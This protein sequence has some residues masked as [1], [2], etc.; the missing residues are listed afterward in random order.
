MERTVNGTIY[1]AFGL[2]IHSVIPFQEL[3]VHSSLE[4][5]I[6]IHIDIDP[7][8]ERR[9]DSLE[10]NRL[11]VVKA[12]FIMFQVPNVATFLIE[13]GNTILV[14]PIEGSNMD[15]VRLFLLGTCMG[16]ILIQ[17]RILPLHGS[18]V[19]I[20]GKAYAIVGESGAGK[21]TLASALL[22]KGYK[23]L[24]D[25]IIPVS[26]DE[27]KE[28]I[29]TPAYPQQ[30]LWQESLDGFGLSS[31]SYKPIY[32]RKT[33]FAIPVLSQFSGSSVPLVGIFE[34]VKTETDE[35]RV[36]PLGKLEVLH[37]VYHHTY[38][39]PFIDQADLREW[40]F[41]MTTQMV[42]SIEAFRIARPVN[43]FTAHELTSLILNK[44]Q[45]EV[46]Q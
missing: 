19:E 22:S 30:K 5:R 38:R 44:L 16:A 24:S 12:D 14:S 35:A 29:V 1:K 26:L 2:S 15:Q 17:R 41:Q 37:T 25:D 21:S 3:P 34:L 36:K 23:L 9:N 11:Y 39:N 6:D 43:R 33:K 7:S 4:T 13:N 46:F 40:H 27:F 18:A 28:P 8:I 45:T 31:K 10:S 32:D 42:H 20:N